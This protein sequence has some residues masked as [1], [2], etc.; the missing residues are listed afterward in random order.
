MNS[1][2]QA[3]WYYSRRR[4]R[5]KNAPVS[6]FTEPRASSIARATD[7]GAHPPGLVVAGVTV[8]D[9]AAGVSTVTLSGAD[10]ADFACDDGLNLVLLST[11][12]LFVGVPKVVTVEVT[13]TV[14]GNASHDFI[15]DVT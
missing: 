15:L 3:A 12:T 14:K 6:V 4:R 10:A 13:N 9:G 7:I 5:A 2:Q 8:V 11:A 1:A